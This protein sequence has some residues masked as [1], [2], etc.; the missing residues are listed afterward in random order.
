M[1]NIRRTRLKAI[2]A[3]VPVMQVNEAVS[4]EELIKLMRKLPNTPTEAKEDGLSE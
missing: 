3:G 2:R 4:Q 1:V